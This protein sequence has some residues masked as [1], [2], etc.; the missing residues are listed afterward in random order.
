MF[1]HECQVFQRLIPE[2]DPANPA[3]AA[4]AFRHFTRLQTRVL[5]L[6]QAIDVF[7]RDI[8]PFHH[9]LPFQ[10][11]ASVANPNSQCQYLRAKIRIRSCHVSPARDRV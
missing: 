6:H 11:A 2:D 3:R 9:E 8:A 10:T 7:E 4:S 5:N 1:A